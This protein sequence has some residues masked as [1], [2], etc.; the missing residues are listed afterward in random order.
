MFRRGSNVF[1]GGGG[2]YVDMPS[3]SRDLVG[4]R[5]IPMHLDI[6]VDKF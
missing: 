4:H 3:D 5:F 1:L 2:G 6:A